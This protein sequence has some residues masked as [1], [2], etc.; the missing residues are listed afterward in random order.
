MHLD[1]QCIYVNEAQAR[2][3]MG[4]LQYF[5][6]GISVH[7]R[8]IS[9]VKARYFGI[10]MIVEANFLQIQASMDVL[11]SENRYQSSKQ[12]FKYSTTDLFAK[13]I[14]LLKI[15]N[16]LLKIDQEAASSKIFIA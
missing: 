7:V 4:S 10:E 16:L 3:D 12:L 13:R 1:F 14:K 8:F 2:V 5:F 9:C 11:V 6:L 15:S